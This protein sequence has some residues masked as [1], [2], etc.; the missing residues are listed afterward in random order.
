M[1]YI[2]SLSSVT[3]T[4]SAYNYLALTQI[5]IPLEQVN[6]YSHPRPPLMLLV[7]IYLAYF[8]RF[9]RTVYAL[10]NNEQSTR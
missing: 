9:G 7:A 1:A 3:I 10:G 4:D 2:I 6:L 5:F 8:T